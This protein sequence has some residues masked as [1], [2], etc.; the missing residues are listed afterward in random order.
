MT[1]RKHKNNRQRLLIAQQAAVILSESG[2][3]DFLAAKTKAAQ[4]MGVFDTTQLPNNIEIEQALIDYHRLFCSTEQPKMLR[5]LRQAAL[6]AMTLFSNF[7]PKLVGSVLAGTSDEHSPVHLHVFA[8]TTEE[9]T[10]FLI[11]QHIPFDIG[12]QKVRFGPDSEQIQSTFSFIA[13]EIKFLLTVF[14]A[15][16]QRQAPMSPVDGKTMKRANLGE[17][18]NLLQANIDIRE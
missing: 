6:K 3:R 13:G 8:N 14:V 12:E 9:L 15:Q 4:R 16:G 2:N 17:V 18:Q 7:T 1:R 10:V 11:N 5:S